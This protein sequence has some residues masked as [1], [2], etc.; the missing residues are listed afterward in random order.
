MGK[1]LYVKASLTANGSSTGILTIADTSLFRK[2]CIVYLSATGLD[3]QSLIVDQ[4]LS[5]TQLA[6]KLNNG[7]NYNRFDCSAYTT[8]LSATLTQPEQED[9]FGYDNP[10]E[11]TG[12]SSSVSSDGADVWVGTIV[13]T[14][15]A[16]A[17]SNTAAPFTIVSGTTYSIQPDV[18][19]YVAT[20]V[21]QADAIAKAVA[22]T[23][24]RIEANALYDRLIP[25]GHT[26]LAVSAVAGTVNAKVNQ[27]I[28]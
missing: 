28:K 23:G 8:A 6:V 15:T 10:I 5:S 11:V 14:A 27:L 13:A 1:A 24:V 9:F 16:V 18:E 26:H 25:S 12:S 4:I 2:A 3:T 22:A 19:C 21:S 17:N 7:Y 20:G